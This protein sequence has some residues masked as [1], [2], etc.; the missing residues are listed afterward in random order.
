MITLRD[1]LIHDLETC[2]ERSNEALADASLVSL[3]LAPEQTL[4]SLRNQLY[5]G[6]HGMAARDEETRELVSGLLAGLRPDL[7]ARRID[8]LTQTL[9][10]EVFDTPL[11]IPAE[12]PVE[13]AIALTV[14]A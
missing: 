10:T 3:G 13:L 1:K 4:T 8:M 14:G 9:L 5:R 7:G 2:T 12:T 6:R 11:Q